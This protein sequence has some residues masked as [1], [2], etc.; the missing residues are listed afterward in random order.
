M[1]YYN[2]RTDCANFVSQCLYAGGVE[3]TNE[4]YSYK[5]ETKINK[6]LS[7]VEFDVGEPWRLAAKQYE[8]FSDPDN[9]Y[10]SGEVLTVE[11][12]TISSVAGNSKIQMGDLLYF[13]EDG[14]N[15]HHATI[16]T[17]VCGGEIYYAGHTS[18]R[19]DKA[20]SEA[21][22]SEVCY[23]IRLRDDA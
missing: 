21:I 17:K 3:M 15:P 11:A 4:W 8:Y 16:I 7:V 6:L 20:L 23:I 18:S 22:G 19:F 14:T 12:S 10:I 1:D 9:G 5:R 2:Y 13:A